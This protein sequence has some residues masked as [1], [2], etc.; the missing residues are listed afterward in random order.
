MKTHKST[1]LI[2]LIALLLAAFA[3]AM[4]Q[5]G[6]TPTDQKKQAET[7]CAME[8]CCCNG[9][10]CPMKKDGTA[11]AEAKEGCCCSGDSCD[12]NKE[13]MNKNHPEGQEGDGCCSGD[14]C[15]MSKHAQHANKMHAQHDK[16]THSADGS[17][18]KMKHKDMKQE[19]KPK[20]N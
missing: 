20:T 9:G 2:T 10:S 12:M 7:C 3:V 19:A 8:T 11:T 15:D 4:A 6:P 18:C 5:Q 13:S 16:K 14:S 1:I 17:C